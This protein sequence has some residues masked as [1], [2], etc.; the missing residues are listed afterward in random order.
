MQGLDSSPGSRARV[1]H[2]SKVSYKHFHVQP[3]GRVDTGQ[4]IDAFSLSRIYAAQKS[5]K[6]MYRFLSGQIG[7]EEIFQSSPEFSRVV[8]RHCPSA[9]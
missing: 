6:R 5:T 3:F 9:G 4:V 7:V 1:G 8:P 2:Q